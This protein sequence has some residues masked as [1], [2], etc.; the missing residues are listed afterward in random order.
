MTTFKLIKDTFSKEDYERVINFF[1]ENINKI[2]FCT[3]LN[4]N[5]ELRS[6]KY[7]VQEWNSEDPLISN[8]Y[9]VLKNKDLFDEFFKIV[10]EIRFGKLSLET[11][12]QFLRL[13]FDF[14]GP[15]IS[16]AVSIFCAL[17]MSNT[18]SNTSK[19]IQS[20]SFSNDEISWMN[21]LRSLQN[22][23]RRLNTVE[24]YNHTLKSFIESR[25][26]LE[27]FFYIDYEY[28]FGNK[29]TFLEDLK[30]SYLITSPHLCLSLENSNLG[31]FKT[32]KNF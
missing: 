31:P 13:P 10:S 8:L 22:V 18:F 14:V 5:V 3:L 20:S 26:D 15:S 11:H 7:S 32:Y 30:G 12:K 27:A 25:D 29:I 4:G 21:C 16:R 1:P 19:N 23:H 17:N 24:I 9:I 28:L 6:D 2:Y